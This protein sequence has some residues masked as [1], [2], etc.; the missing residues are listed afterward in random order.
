MGD[1]LRISE[2]AAGI[3]FSTLDLIPFVDVSDTSISASGK[4][5]KATLANFVVYL[6]TVVTGIP[7]TNAS[8]LTTGTVDFNR[9]PVGTSNL[10]I[11]QG[12]HLHT[13]VYDPLGAGSAAAAAVTPS[14]LGLVIG[15]NVLAYSAST[16]TGN[17]VRAAGATIT[18]ATLTTAII[19]GS[20]NTITNIPFTSLTATITAAQLLNGGVNGAN[21]VPQLTAAGK[22]PAL[23]GSLI[24]NLSSGFANPMTTLGDV[25]YGDAAGAATRL[26]GPIANVLYALTSQGNGSIASVPSY[27][28]VTSFLTIAGA[29]IG[30][31]T[32]DVTGQLLKLADYVTT[33]ATPASGLTLY[34]DGSSRL[35]WMH[36]TGFIAKLNASSI[37]GNRVYTLPNAAG[38]FVLGSGTFT[39]NGTSGSLIDIGTGGVLGTAAYT[40]STSYQAVLSDSSG[41]RGALGD[42]TGTGVA[43][44]NNGPT[45]IAPVLGAATATTINK[46]QI[47]A[48]ATGSILDIGEGNVFSTRGAF[49]GILRFTASTDITA[50]TSGTLSTLAGAETLTNK[51]LTGPIADFVNFSNSAAPAVPSG[52]GRLFFDTSNRFS[53]KGTNGFVRT[54]DGIANT[55][56][57][58]YTLPDAAGTL[59]LLASPAFTGTPAAPTATL[60]TNTTQLATTAFVIANAGGGSVAN[61]TGTIGLTAVNGSASSAIRSDGAPALSQAIIPTWTGLHTFSQAPAANTVINGL[62]LLDPT[63]APST[64]NQQYSPSIQWTGSGWKT[65]A[66][67]GPQAVEYR[68]YVVP[69]QGSS[70]PTGIWNLDAAIAGGAYAT[71]F[72]VT[73]T[74][75]INLV[76]SLSLTPGGSALDITA[77]KAWGWLARSKM[78]SAAD[79]RITIANNAQTAFTR[80]AFGVETSSGASLQISTTGITAGLGDGTSGGS[81]TASGTFTATGATALNSDATL[82]NANLICATA[83]KGL[84]LK[85]GT[86]ARAGNATLVAGAVTVTNTTVTANTIIMLTRKTS[87]GTLGTAITYTLSAGASFTINSDSALDTSTF[88]YHLMELN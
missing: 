70:A 56:D 15:T 12:N 51:T 69:V 11:A 48:P 45:L 39:I 9:L 13:G 67:A 16:G 32:S 54:F 64:G 50:P 7:T 65:T 60:G 57:R 37:T 81:F 40:D 86:G 75:G 21:Q 24:T 55:A 59:A 8:L 3:S 53:W 44:F 29:A 47:T 82:T 52:A 23:D 88:S 4:T 58:I 17:I 2:L 79:G 85:S 76:S 80:L 62:L 6:N 1:N 25:I 27:A 66:T 33:P 22:Y 30:S 14:T 84:Q 72:G 68:A 49:G 42:E 35:S 10:T 78:L 71:V 41:L 43:V 19:N 5:K 77:G 74:G 28:A 83:G 18:G 73:S 46:M 87:G 26:A 31:T 38:T 63:V 34:T 20:L 61:P 36:S